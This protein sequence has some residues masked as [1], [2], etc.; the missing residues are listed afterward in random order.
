M[1]FTPEQVIEMAMQADGGISADH[2]NVD[3]L[4]RLCTLAA[5]AALEGA[6]GVC[7]VQQ[8]IQATEGRAVVAAC[9]AASIRAMKEKA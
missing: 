2:I 6:I 5:D 4:T 1:K 7:H 3:A 9:C 8:Q